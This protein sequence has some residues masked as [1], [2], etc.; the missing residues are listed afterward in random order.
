MRTARTAVVEFAIRQEIIT[1]NNNSNNDEA[2][3]IFVYLLREQARHTHY[4]LTNLNEE[5]CASY[6]YMG[7]EPMFRDSLFI[8]PHE[9]RWGENNG[10][11]Q[12]I[13]LG[14]DLFEVILCPSQAIS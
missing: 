13:K 1:Q 7:S 4:F 8:I 12:R 14:F 2:F 9:N 3:S 11:E 10:K 6:E 5:N